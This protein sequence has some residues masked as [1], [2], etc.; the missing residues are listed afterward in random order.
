[1]NKCA[2]ASSGVEYEINF[3]LTSLTERG[4]SK[5]EFLPVSPTAVHMDAIIG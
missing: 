5:T 4:F 2:L 3:E 1:M